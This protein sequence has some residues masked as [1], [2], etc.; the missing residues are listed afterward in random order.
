LGGKEVGGLLVII[1]QFKREK[2]KQKQKEY[3]LP[4]SAGC[5]LSVPALSQSLTSFMKE[6]YLAN[7]FILILTVG[8][9]I[10]HINTHLLVTVSYDFP[11]IL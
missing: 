11:I 3:N 7:G 4:D 8:L 2:H 1:L 10:H 9:E 5:T 6:N